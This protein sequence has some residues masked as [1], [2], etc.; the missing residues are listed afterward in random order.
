MSC[1]PVGR[2]AEPKLALEASVRWLCTLGLVAAVV[3]PCADAGDAQRPC[4]GLLDEKSNGSDWSA[5]EEKPPLLTDSQCEALKS[6]ELRVPLLQIPQNE[7]DPMTFSLGA[8]NGGG[9]LRFKIPFS[10]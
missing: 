4:Y 7:E 6:Q 9:A 1:P 3:A 5:P 8:K 10:F 2:T